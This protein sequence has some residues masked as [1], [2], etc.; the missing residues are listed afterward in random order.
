MTCPCRSLRFL[1]AAGLMI[2][3]AAALS[4]WFGLFRP[5]PAAGA[6]AKVDFA[7]EVQP[8]LADSCLKCHGAPAADA[9]KPPAGGLRLD[10]KTA[11]LKGGKS[12]KA[13]LPGKAKDSLL[14]KVLQ[15]PVRLG[16]R[17]VPA[18]PKSMR[19]GESSALAPEKIKLIRKWIDQGAR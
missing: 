16:G 4:A 5:A 8:I 6:D 17:E 9:K 12:G 7:K 11:A 1:K 15:G 3:A 18:M 19:G 14:Y 13:V 2:A 10:D